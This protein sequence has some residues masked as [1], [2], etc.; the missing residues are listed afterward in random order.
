MGAPRE[1]HENTTYPWKVHTRPMR[2]PREFH[3]P[4]LEPMQARSESHGN[5]NT[6]NPNKSPMEDPWETRGNPMGEHDLYNL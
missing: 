5:T 3:G 2:E 6:V 1:S 4:S